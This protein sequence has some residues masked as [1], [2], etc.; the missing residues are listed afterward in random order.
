MSIAAAFQ[1][2]GLSV[3]LNTNASSNTNQSALIKL[4]DMGV[5]TI[6]SQVRAIVTGSSNVWIWMS[7]ATQVAALPVPGTTSAGTPAAGFM[8]IPNIVE[9][10]TINAWS[11]NPGAVTPASEGFYVNTISTGSSITFYLTFGEGL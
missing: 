11:L 6:P 1:P 8:L 3:A 2:I 7:P 4:T 5:T 9:I 10:F